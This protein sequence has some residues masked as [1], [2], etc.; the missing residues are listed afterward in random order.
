MKTYDV[1]KE[2]ALPMMLFSY[3]TDVGDLLLVHKVE[4]R[5]RRTQATGPCRR[6]SPS[7]P[8]AHGSARTRA[9]RSRA[10]SHRS[11]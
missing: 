10:P 3:A 4:G 6:P 2:F 1:I 11:D 9:R 5:P 8:T 7:R